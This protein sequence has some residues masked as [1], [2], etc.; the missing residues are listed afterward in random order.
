SVDIVDNNKVGLYSADLVGQEVVLVRSVDWNLDQPGHRS[1]NPCADELRRVLGD[2][3]HSITPLR[4]CDDKAATDPFPSGK[5]LSKRPPALFFRAVEP[6]SIR[7]LR[8]M[9]P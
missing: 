4:T 2:Q 1:T 6:D 3:R 9:V 5:H 8:S 7:T